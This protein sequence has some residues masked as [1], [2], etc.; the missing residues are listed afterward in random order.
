MNSRSSL[1]SLFGQTIGTFALAM[2]TALGLGPSGSALAQTPTMTPNFTAKIS[3]L[4]IR[5]PIL[6]NMKNEYSVSGDEKVYVSTYLNPEGRELVRETSTL[7]LKDGRE[8]LKKF[9]VE[10]LQLQTDANVTV[11]DG[12]AL[13][14]LTKDGKTQSAEEKLTDDFIVSSTL[15]AYLR[16]TQNWERIMKGERV[17]ARFAVLDRRETVGF[18]FFKVKEAEV[19]GRKA[20]SIKMKPSSLL[21][22]ALV[23]PLYFYIDIE[24]GLLLEM[25]GRSAVK[26]GE[27]GKWKDFDG[28]TVYTHTAK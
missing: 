7:Q 2:A 11:Q 13:F 10:H 15:V 22:S 5:E 20:V 19:Q 17:R 4:K 12:K 23:D 28:F 24:N 8:V 21:I 18:E 6:F 9:R 16:Q 25:E 27:A 3:A 14:Q 1:S 26:T